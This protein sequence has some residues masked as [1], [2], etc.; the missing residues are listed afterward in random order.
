MPVLPGHYDLIVNALLKRSVVPLLG[1]GANLC[2]RPEGFQW[3]SG[4]DFLPSG[5]ELSGHL[6]ETAGYPGQDHWELGRV[7][8]FLELELG[9]G[10]LYQELRG[11]FDRDY[12]LTPLHRFLAALPA[13]VRRIRPRPRYQLIVTT[14]Y[15][16][17]LE[18]AF[19]D[20][21]EPFDTVVYVADGQN[22]GKFLHIRPD[23]ASTL[24]DRPN[25]YH[26]FDLEQRP[27]ILKIH[28][29]VVRADV[30]Q[31]SYVI[32]E[33]HYID[34]L[35]RTDISMLLP[36][37]LV[38]ELKQSH[39][40]FLGYSLR[41]W[42]LRVIL[43]RIWSER[44]LKFKSWSVQLR[45]AAVDQKFWQRREVEILDVTIEEYVE[46]LEASLAARDAAEAAP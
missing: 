45:P 14:N 43:H 9:S 7:S 13:H 19:R 22:K 26:A 17:L 4:T 46:G 40:L 15:D 34:Y 11:I 31:D 33:D 37:Q 27:V 23:G 5:G 39:F 18:R 12:P 20:A 1:A 42:N 3:S 10:V 41:D 38:V 21:G 29:A 24:I 32:T 2:G 8:Q 28:G 16:D 36:V 30:S 35:T 44:S 25:E 6:A